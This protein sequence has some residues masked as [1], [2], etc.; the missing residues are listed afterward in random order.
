MHSGG[1]GFVVPEVSGNSLFLCVLCVCVCVGVE[2]AGRANLD[3]ETITKVKMTLYRG[4]GPYIRNRCYTLN[5]K[6]KNNC[7]NWHY[8]EE[9]K[10]GNNLNVHQ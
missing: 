8:L 1:Q 5:W 10:T 3:N 2:G 9:R 7:I 6:R 4:V